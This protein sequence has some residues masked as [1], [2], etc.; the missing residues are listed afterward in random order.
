MGAYR[1][2]SSDVTNSSSSAAASPS[3]VWQPCTT[4][5]TCTQGTPTSEWNHIY[6]ATM[7]ASVHASTSCICGRL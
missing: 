5:L 4:T 7:L 1:V 3:T 2:R 6:P